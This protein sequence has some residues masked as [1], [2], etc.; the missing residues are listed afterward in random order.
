MS[1]IR[2]DTLA[3]YIHHDVLQ[4]SVTDG[5]MDHLLGAS[6]QVQE[7]TVRFV[8][9]IAS[10]CS[11]RTYLMNKGDIVKILVDLLLSDPR[12]TILR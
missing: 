7:F 6:Y 8:N 3:T 2:R 12:D 10:E 9:V 4:V 11:G 1:H 5:V